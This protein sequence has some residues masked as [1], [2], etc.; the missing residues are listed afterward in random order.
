M[1]AARARSVACVTLALIVALDFASRARSIARMPYSTV[2]PA[3]LAREMARRIYAE[4]HDDRPDWVGEKLLRPGQ[5]AALFQVHRRTI[6]EWARAGLLDPI[7]TPGGHR[8]FRATQV[9]ALLASQRK[10]RKKRS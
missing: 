10:R 2:G 5:V 6:S 9:R 7:V 4:E 3:A 8:R 1:G